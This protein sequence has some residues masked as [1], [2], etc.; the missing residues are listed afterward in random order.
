MVAARGEGETDTEKNK[1][2]FN[3]QK[4]NIS[5]NLYVRSA[6]VKLNEHEGVT[7]CRCKF[8]HHVYKV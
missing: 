1:M 6:A 4:S 5:I 7:Q 2:V 3:T 8:Q